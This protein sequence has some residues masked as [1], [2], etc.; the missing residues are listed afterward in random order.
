MPQY[1]IFAVS[2]PQNSLKPRFLELE[3]STI[4]P[5]WALRLTPIQS[6]VLLDGPAS[7]LRITNLAKVA[8]LTYSSFGYEGG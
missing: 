5:V 3:F 1:P 4:G 8:V 2:D 7:G 6:A